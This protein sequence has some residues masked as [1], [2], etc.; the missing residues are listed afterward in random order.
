MSVDSIASREI[1][2]IQ[3]T[4]A[5]FGGDKELFA[6]MTTM[7]LED[8]PQLFAE[9]GRAVNEGDA[10]AVRMKAHALRG[11][12]AGCGG[13]RAAEAAQ[14]LEDAGQQANLKGAATLLSAL[15]AEVDL[16]MQAIRAYQA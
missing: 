4:M 14:S 3:G 10:T 6:E 1:L 11:V 7:L 2:D 16:L 5:R 8:A 13:V 12:V 9:V 15:E